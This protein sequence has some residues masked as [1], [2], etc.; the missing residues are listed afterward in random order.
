MDAVYTIGGKPIVLDVDRQIHQWME[1]Y[2]PFRFTTNF[3]LP[4]AS[5]RWNRTGFHLGIGLGDDSW[6]QVPPLGLNELYWPT[7][8]TRFAIGY[9]LMRSSD[10]LSIATTPLKKAV[11]VK[12]ESIQ[13]FEAD[14][15]I[16]WMPITAAGNDKDL[17]LVIAVDDR[18]WWQGIN[19]GDPQLDSTS[20]WSDVFYDVGQVLQ[21]EEIETSE[22]S[23]DYLAPDWVSLVRR[24]ELASEYIDA[25]SHSVNQ[26]I[27][28]QPSG[29]LE[30]QSFTDAADVHEDNLSET[31]NYF[32]A[33]NG[34]TQQAVPETIEVI[35]EG[36]INHIPCPHPYKY[37]YTVPDDYETVQ[38]TKL[39]VYSTC[40]ADYTTNGVGG[41]PDNESYLI[42][43]GDKFCAEWLER[44]EKSYDYTFQGIKKWT[45]TAFDDYVHYRIGVEV[46]DPFSNVDRVCTT[47]V[48]SL[49][50]TGNPIYNLSQDSAL[51]VL[52]AKNYVF[53]S[54]DGIDARSSSTPGSAEVTVYQLSSDTGNLTTTGITDW[55]VNNWS[56]TSVYAGVYGTAFVD[57]WCTAWVNNAECPS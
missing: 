47:R 50:L 37:E 48:Q 40:F 54:V 8:A 21:G 14:M 38:N 36:L 44:F 39:T 49:P 32:I 17:Y 42:A 3:G 53:Y 25:V 2:Q 33:G 56:D 20:E 1:A 13:T 9:F 24:Y 46:N 19:V 4:M 22:I 55:T 26:R 11:K 52:T 51:K 15:F 45:L 57:E 31:V 34:Q 6:N 18:Y 43:L 16:T 12:F 30:S 7:G 5:R 10:V 35:F 23:T 29:T 41:E 27:V 28:R